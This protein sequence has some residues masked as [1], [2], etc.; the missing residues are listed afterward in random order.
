M[1]FIH[2]DVLQIS[3]TTP[4]VGNVCT[5]VEGCR[6]EKRLDQISMKL[7]GRKKGADWALWDGAGKNENNPY[8]N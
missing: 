8:T 1:Q 3:M 6:G 2:H 4:V 5:Y 7:L